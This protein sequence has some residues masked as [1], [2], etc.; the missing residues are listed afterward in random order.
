[1]IENTPQSGQERRKHE[2]FIISK[3]VRLYFADK[4]VAGTLRDISVGGAAIRIHTP[5]D[6]DTKVKVDIG[7]LGTFSGQVVRQIEKEVFGVM[8]SISA[9]QAVSLAAKLVIVYHGV[10]E[11][12]SE[13]KPEDKRTPF[14]P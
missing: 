7:E 2:R 9:A 11:A 8:F 3:P 10:A 13:E 12:E 5:I 1:M 4:S 14:A 6:L